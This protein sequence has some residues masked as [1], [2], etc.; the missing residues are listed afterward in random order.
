M[1]SSGDLERV[2]LLTL[3]A[4]GAA[5]ADAAETGSEINLT[6]VLQG[7]S[8]GPI[9]PFPSTRAT[10]GYIEAVYMLREETALHDDEVVSILCTVSGQT[11]ADLGK[12]A[13]HIDPRTARE[14]KNSLPWCVAA[15]LI[16]NKIN[17]NAFTP[18]AIS[19][20]RILTLAKKVSC[21]VDP[22]LPEDE[23]RVTVNRVRGKPVE[24]VVTVSLESDLMGMNES[25]PIVRAAARSCGC[26]ALESR[27]NRLFE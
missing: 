27:D 7:D 11:L 19:N 16:L 2:R 10:H 17:R 25:N 5:C 9:L 21:A 22:A 14:A 13:T 15:S 23:S 20:P 4:L 6:A 3:H 26:R 24:C 8:S 1:T 12:H 18:E